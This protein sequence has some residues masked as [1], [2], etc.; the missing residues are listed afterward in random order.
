MAT[1]TSDG[2]TVLLKGI[3]LSFT[4]G[5]YEK[6]KSAEDAA[7]K[8]STNIILEASSPH[9]EANKAACVAA[10]KAAGEKTWKQPEAY[11]TIADDNPKRVC[12][13]R[14]ERFKNGDG[15]IY[16]GYE[17][18]WAMSA[19]GPSGGQK[20][21]KLLDRHKR[22]VEVADI[23]DVMYSGVIADC[24]VSFF[25]TD[26][27]SKG[28]FATVDLIRSRQEGDRM[29]GGFVATEERMSAL[30]DLDDDDDLD[31]GPASGGSD[32]DFG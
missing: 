32:D 9:F 4:D 2:R 18:N 31:A 22:D 26:K 6:K 17:G 10:M 16:A 28:I 14:G 25:G 8:H 23:P 15:V 21:P 19:S 27:G 20:R 5:L 29:A 1:D 3:R 13:K 30:D 24:Y 11:R 7:P 12:F